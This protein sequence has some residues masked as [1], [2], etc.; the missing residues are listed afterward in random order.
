MAS[1]N[2]PQFVSMVRRTYAEA[3]QATRLKGMKG[4]PGRELAVTATARLVS[5]RAGV[6]ISDQEVLSLVSDP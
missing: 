3:L 2:D 4:L 5:S 1:K 6:A